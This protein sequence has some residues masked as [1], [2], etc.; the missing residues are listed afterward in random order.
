MNRMKKCLAFCA[1]LCVLMLALSASAAELP[2]VYMTKDISPAGLEKVYK[3]MNWTPEGRVAVKLSTGEPPASNYLRPEL[4][5]DLVQSVHGTIVECNTAYNGSRAETAMHMQVAKDHGFTAIAPVDIMDAE[6][7]ISLPVPGGTRLKENFVGSHFK[8]YDSF[9]V[10][11]ISKGMRWPASA[12]PSRTSP[13][14]SVPA[15]AS[16]GFTPAARVKLTRG[17]A[18]RTSSSS[19]WA[20]PERLLS[21]H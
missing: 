2:E 11:T 16:R 8:N 18:C 7:S 6:G 21:R 1:G 9:L 17:A 15:W 14:A 12:A 10:L 19:P 3:A 20:T 13:S 5:R 4:I